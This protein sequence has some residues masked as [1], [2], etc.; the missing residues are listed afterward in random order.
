MNKV[1]ITFANETTHTIE[2]VEG[3]EVSAFANWYDTE[4]K[5]NDSINLN[6][7]HREEDVEL[8]LREVIDVIGDNEIISVSW[9]DDD[10]EI[11][12]LEGTI[13]PSWNLQ[14]NPVLSEMLNFTM[15]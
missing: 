1:I 14:A 5:F 3:I 10:K 15:E 7:V 11:L 2:C 9:M 8:V 6:C 4:R 13:R 12:I